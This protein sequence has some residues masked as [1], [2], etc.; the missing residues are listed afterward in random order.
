MQALLRGEGTVLHELRDHV[1][2]VVDPVANALSST[3]VRTQVA[4]VMGTPL[5]GDQIDERYGCLRW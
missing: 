4:Q 1:L 3:A 2:V 5:L